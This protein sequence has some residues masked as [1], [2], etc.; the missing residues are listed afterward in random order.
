MT[1][2]SR[3]PPGDARGIRGGIVARDGHR[4]GGDGRA[5]CGQ[6]RHSQPGVKAREVGEARREAAE[7]DEIVGLGV[8]RYDLGHRAA[9]RIGHGVEIGA[10]VAHRQCD[11]RRR[12]VTRNI[13]AGPGRDQTG[14]GGGNHRRDP[15]GVDAGRLETNQQGAGGGHQVLECAR[16]RIGQRGSQPGGRRVVLVVWVEV[17]QNG[18]VTVRAQL[19]GPAA[20]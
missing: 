20:S 4:A 9:G 3:Q 1:P 11:H 13:G 14:D 18:P 5:G 10:V 12:I 6:P 19:H 7:R 15:G 16:R 8:P 2:I 17:D